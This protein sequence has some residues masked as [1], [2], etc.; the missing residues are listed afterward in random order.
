[1]TKIGIIGAGRIVPFHI[2]A[3]IEAG[4]QIEA[5]CAT[6]NS[7][8]SRKIAAVHQISK[9]YDE[10]E[11]LLH[12]DIEAVLIAVSKENL[13][14]VL[15]K[16]LPTGKKILIEK[17]VFIGMNRTLPL[18]SE[19]VMVAYNRRFY[20]TVKTLK[21][22]LEAADYSSVYMH[23]PELSSLPKPNLERIADEIA[24]NTVHYF[25]LVH[26][27]LKEGHEP[28]NYQI[29]NSPGASN[30]YFINFQTAKTNAILHLTFGSPGNYR[31]QA[32]SGHSSYILSPLESFT[33]FD[34]MQVFE[35]SQEFP[36]RRYLPS[37]SSEQLEDFVEDSRFKPGF[38]EQSKEFFNF[39]NG[40]QLG[41]GATLQD[42]AAAANVSASIS[43]KLRELS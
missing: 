24:G 2:D 9:V 41:C 19:N 13:F 33:E 31:I 22:K 10:I 23:I 35:P 4:F 18:F 15:M 40:A 21:D 28:L 39:V 6:Q 38:L 5:I 16:A 29:L 11:R 17:P 30:S 26:F 3:L 7:L 14:Q 27:L 12:S 25:D 43:S 8:N 42:A 36:L 1:M 34:S 32:E 37:K 20:R